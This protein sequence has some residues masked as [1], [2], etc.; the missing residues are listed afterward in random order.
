MQPTGDV[1]LCV[2]IDETVRKF[3]IARVSVDTSY[4]KGEAGSNVHEGIPI[5]DLVIGNIP[6]SSSCRLKN[7]IKLSE[8]AEVTTRSQEKR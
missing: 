6:G 3:L 1:H 5:Y 4:Y 7:Q 2:L 8:V